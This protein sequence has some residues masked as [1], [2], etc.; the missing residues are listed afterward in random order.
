VPKWIRFER[1]S[2]AKEEIV[3][4]LTGIIDTET[5]SDEKKPLNLEIYFNPEDGAF[6]Q[7]T[8]DEMI[9]PEH[10][11][12]VSWNLR[13]KKGVSGGNGFLDYDINSINNIEPEDVV[14]QLVLAKKYPLTEEM[15]ADMSEEDIK[16]AEDDQVNKYLPYFLKAFDEVAKGVS[17]ENN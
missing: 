1:V 9:F 16:K 6:L 5:D 12:I 3:D 17:D 13:K 15:M 14:R 10:V 4:K 7:K 2:G 8:V 11:R